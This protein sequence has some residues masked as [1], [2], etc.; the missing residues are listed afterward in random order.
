VVCI[1]Q[2]DYEKILVVD[3]TA[4][5]PFFKRLSVA[6]SILPSHNAASP[7]PIK[8]G[9]NNLTRTSVLP[10]YHFTTFL[11]EDHRLTSNS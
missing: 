10:Q 8:K 3:A 6:I 9:A 4:T 2:H 7:G 1:R 11:A 5:M